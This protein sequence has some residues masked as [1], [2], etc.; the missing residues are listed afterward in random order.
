MMDDRPPP[1]PEPDHDPAAYYAAH[2]LAEERLRT[3]AAGPP[4]LASLV[5]IA[6]DHHA[7]HLARWD[8]PPAPPP[9]DPLLV[10]VRHVP[11]ARRT[12]E[13]A[14]RKAPHAAPDHPDGSALLALGQYAVV[15]VAPDLDGVPWARMT[16]GSGSVEV[17]LDDLDVL[18]RVLREAE[19]DLAAMGLIIPEHD[20]RREG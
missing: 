6:D 20:L 2:P 18:T 8:G 9:S 17:P 13:E 10:D 15:T 1:K 11:E 19:R 14:L 12:A 16:G 4:L 7:L 5:K 3:V